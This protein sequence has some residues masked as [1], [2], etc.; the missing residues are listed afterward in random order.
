M[1]EDKGEFIRAT[2]VNVLKQ[3][4]SEVLTNIF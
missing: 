3:M 2:E 1:P 4:E